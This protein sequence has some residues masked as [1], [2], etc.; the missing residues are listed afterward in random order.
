MDA[1]IIALPDRAT[2]ALRTRLERVLDSVELFSAVDTRAITKE[3]LLADPRV[4]VMSKYRV[5]ENGAQRRS[6][7]DIDAR[8]AIGCA[9]S[10]SSIWRKIAM[11]GRPGL[12]LEDDVQVRGS[13]AELWD[14]LQRHLDDPS[15]QIVRMNSLW[16]LGMPHFARAGFH[17]YLLRPEGAQ[18]L[19][20]NLFPLEMHIDLFASIMANLHPEELPEKIDDDAPFVLC[21]GGSLIGHGMSIM[22]FVPN[23][24]T[25]L[26]VLVGLLVVILVGWAIASVF[27]A[28]AY[29]CEAECPRSRDRTKSMIP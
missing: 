16:M 9:L 7:F 22:T 4:S 2:D 8:G 1:Y 28:R 18:L 12:V 15:W 3:E 27:A 21:G 14:A 10:H 29:H 19:L 25:I 23:N 24:E 13:D 26:S 17:A 5:L 6:H 11:T 20:D